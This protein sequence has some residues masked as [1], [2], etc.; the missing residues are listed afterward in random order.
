MR[1]VSGMALEA[2]KEL[3]KLFPN[4]IFSGE[5]KL[6]FRE[7]LTRRK[8]ENENLK[9]INFS[10]CSLK[11]FPYNHLLW[12]LSVVLSKNFLR[13]SLKIFLLK[14]CFLS[15]LDWILEWNLNGTNWTRK[16]QKSIFDW[17]WKFS[18]ILQKA[19]TARNGKTYL[20][21]FAFYLFEVAYLHHSHQMAVHC[22]LFLW[23]LDVA[24]SDDHRIETASVSAS[25]DSVNLV[26]FG[27]VSSQHDHPFRR[28]LHTYYSKLVLYMAVLAQIQ[29]LLY[30]DASFD[31]QG[32]VHVMRL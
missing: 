21:G 13:C 2:A 27:R 18:S 26:V 28:Q 11:K 15:F 30:H 10:L 19:T 5:S 25:I 23:N 24:A 20:D 8:E 12:L 1:V 32:I 16:A 7:S 22:V 4:D 9:N 14:K 29:S 31:G 6:F 3:L 17:L